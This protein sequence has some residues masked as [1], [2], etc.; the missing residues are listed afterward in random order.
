[1]MPEDFSKEIVRLWHCFIR[2][3]TDSKDVKIS[4]LSSSASDLLLIYEEQ[5]LRIKLGGRY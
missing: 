2:I 4:S 5:A 3:L 1:M